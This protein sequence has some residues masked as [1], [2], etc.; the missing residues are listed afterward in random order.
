MGRGIPFGF[1]HGSSLILW[2][3]FYISHYFQ[4]SVK[5][6]MRTWSELYGTVNRLSALVTSA[7]SN[8]VCEEVSSK[9]LDY[10]KKQS[11]LV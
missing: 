11:E 4:A 10:V 3:T 9:L 2:Y 8:I 6:L 1:T 5:S 7:E